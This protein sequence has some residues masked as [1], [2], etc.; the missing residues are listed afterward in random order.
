M[1]KS[2]IISVLAAI[3][4]AVVVVVSVVRNQ[5]T[6]VE[7]SSNFAT[8]VEHS[9]KGIITSDGILYKDKHLHGQWKFLDGDMIR[10]IKSS[11]LPEVIASYPRSKEAWIAS[12]EAS[13]AIIRIEQN[14]DEIS[15]VTKSATVKLRAQDYV[16]EFKERGKPTFFCLGKCDKLKA[17]E[18]PG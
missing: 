12:E 1:K 16:V 7:I 15:V 6:E 10:F 13:D 9:S 3:S 4:L 14:G 2:I 18:L 17:Y 8:V 11:Q 5:K